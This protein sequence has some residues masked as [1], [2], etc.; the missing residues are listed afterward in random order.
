MLNDNDFV[1]LEYVLSVK[2]TGE[3]IDTTDEKLAKEKNIYSETR[4][5]GPILAIIGEH[6]FIDGIEEALLQMDIGTE[7]E[8]EIPPEKAYG[9][10]DPTKVKTISIYKITD[11]HQIRVNKPVLLDDGNIAIVRSVSGNRVVVDLNHP[12][13]GKV[14]LA[15]LKVVSKL[16]EPSSKIKALVKHHLGKN[17]D[18]ELKIDDEAKNIILILPSDVYQWERL[19]DVKKILAREIIKYIYPEYKIIYEEIYDKG[20]VGLG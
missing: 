3:V 2:D 5:Y 17:K 10:R 14:I 6:R 9:N 1:Y 15:K 12:Y 19:S 8:I 7:K 4:E 13:A 16:E 20:T 11:P 18:A